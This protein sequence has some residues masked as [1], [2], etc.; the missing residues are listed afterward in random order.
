MRETI[1]LGSTGPAV[2]ELHEILGIERS[3][4]FDIE[5]HDAVLTFQ[6]SHGLT[7]DGIVG[8]ITWSALLAGTDTDLGG[9]E[10]EEYMLAAGRMVK[11]AE[12]KDVWVPNYYPGTF[13]KQWLVFHH[14][15]GW[16]N[17]YQTIDIW[18]KDSSTV[19]TE[20]VVGGKHISGTDK[21]DGRILR[22]LP[23]GSWAAH[24][25]V[26][27]TQIHRES[28][29]VELCNMGGLTKGGY[30][31]NKIWVPLQTNT[32]YTAY[33]NP[34]SESEVY[35]LGWTYRFHRYFHKYSLK[36]IE[37]C[38]EIAL[39]VS[40][41][42]GIDLKEGIQKLINTYSVEKAFEYNLQ[43]AGSKPGIYAHGHVF[44]EKNDIF[45]Q[46]DMIDMIMSL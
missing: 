6:K 31:K 28:I 10:F 44:A 2:E 40:A 16:D 37:A 21:Y 11:N 43:Y 13:K 20:F 18:D 27:N 15:A 33:G 41:E 5:T 23:K 8:P 46:Q 32:F 9:K 29:G 4:Y 22:C 30:Y 1:K 19:A 25:T 14:T 42:Y 35:D 38:R 3:G 39:S 24:L 17:P 7:A 45:P 36:Q 34:V 26:G 12:G